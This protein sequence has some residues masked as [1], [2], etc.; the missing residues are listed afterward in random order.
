MSLSLFQLEKNIS[1]VGVVHLGP[2][3]AKNIYDS[4]LFSC[5]NN[6]KKKKKVTGLLRFLCFALFS[7]VFFF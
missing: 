1:A 3:L 2:C 4:R 6:Y 5:P 7:I